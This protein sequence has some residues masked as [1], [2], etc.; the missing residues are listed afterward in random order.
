MIFI[1]PRKLFHWLLDTKFPASEVNNI[2]LFWSQVSCKV[3]GLS[4]PASAISLFFHEGCLRAAQG[5]S[6]RLRI[7]C[8][9]RVS[10][11]IYSR[12]Y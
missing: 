9:T 11:S 1:G 4:Q 3:I 12:Y 7:Y 10:S 6:V 8:D 5:P 2:I